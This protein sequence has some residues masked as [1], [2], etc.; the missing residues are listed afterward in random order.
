MNRLALLNRRDPFAEF[1]ALVR[2]AFG[3]AATRPSGFSPA[4]DVERDGDDAVVRI[5]LPGVDVENDVTVEVDEGR[6]VVRGERRD[7]RTE[8]N[9]GRSLRE[10]HY[11]EFHRSFSL[12]KH[13]DSDAIS[14]SYDSGVLT[15]R[16]IG[17]Y[18][19]KQAQRIAISNG[20]PAVETT[21][22]ES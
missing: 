13:V 15:V 10:I 17:A 20:A 19:S 9:D 11:G 14:A 1:D 3:P 4:A 6:L 18:A 5:E 8:E 12:P 16:V 2:N 22:D 7:E 21:S